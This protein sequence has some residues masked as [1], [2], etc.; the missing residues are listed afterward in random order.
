MARLEHGNQGQ[1]QVCIAAADAGCAVG[2]FLRSRLG[3]TRAQISQMKFRENG[4]RVNGERVRVTH[5]LR[6]GDLLELCLR[7]QTRSSEQLVAEYSEPEILYEDGDVIALWKEPGVVVHPS[8]GHYKDTLS[9]RLH[10]YFERKQESVCIRSIGRLDADTSGILVFAKNQFAAARLWQQRE[11]GMFCKWYLAWCEGAFAQEAAETE[12]RVDAP[13]GPMAGER[14]KMCVTPEGK[15]AVTFYRV[16]RQT[17]RGALLRLH[18]LTGRTHQ[19]RVHMAWL[20]HPLLGDSLYGNGTPGQTHAMLSAYRAEFRQPF[21]GER[22]V[23]EKTEPVY[24]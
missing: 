11:D 21:T 22:V 7:D 10:G 4:I 1:Y 2:V 5:S 24:R 14:M 12:Q 17:G 19:I 15:R 3:F 16:L 23:V 13:I 9:N 20:G 6:A 8:G 18:L